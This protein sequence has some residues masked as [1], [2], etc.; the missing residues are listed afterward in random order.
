MKVANV[1]ELRK[2][3]KSY[4]DYIADT[5]D[6]LIVNGNGKTVVM[7]SLEDYNSLDETAYLL[8]NKANAKRL[9]ESMEA[10]A[11]KKVIKKSLK[12]LAISTKK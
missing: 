1:S 3:L 5:S 6:T 10:L 9:K 7:I 12:D 4:I 11:G 2:N 8:S